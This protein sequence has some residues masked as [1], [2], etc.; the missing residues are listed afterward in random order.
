MDWSTMCVCCETFYKN[1]DSF[2]IAQSEFRTE[3]GIHSN[4]AV[5]SAHAIKNWVQNFEAT[6]S[7]LKKRGGSVKTACT[8]ENVAAVREAIEQSPRR[9]A[10]HHATSLGLSEA[11][12]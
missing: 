5:P 6:G 3:F 4:R 7:T 10:H 8:P 1:S 9:S 12:V 11:R 2:V